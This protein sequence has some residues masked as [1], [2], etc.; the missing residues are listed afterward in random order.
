MYWL[1]KVVFFFTKCLYTHAGKSR[2]TLNYSITSS[3]KPNNLPM[4][5]FMIADVDDD[6]H[7]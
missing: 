1:V 5:F 3:P 7:F 2:R 4:I 6:V